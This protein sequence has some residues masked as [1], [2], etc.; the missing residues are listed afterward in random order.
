MITLREGTTID[1][2]EDNENNYHINL[3]VQAGWVEYNSCFS[4]DAY[5]LYDGLRLTWEGNEVADLLSDHYKWDKVKN[6]SL[7]G[8]PF[9]LILDY[10]RD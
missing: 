2:V 10:L 4:C 8:G 1:K 9:Q 5:H 3:L 6:S 7:L